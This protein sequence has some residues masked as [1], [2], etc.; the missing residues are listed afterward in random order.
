MIPF[1]LSCLDPS[2]LHWFNI[3]SPFDEETSCHMHITFTKPV[4][5][6]AIFPLLFYVNK[7]ECECVYPNRKKF[8]P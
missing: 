1:S 3:E 4:L 8:I 2:V 5:V 7:L 6:N